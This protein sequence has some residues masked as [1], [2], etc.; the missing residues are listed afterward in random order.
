VSVRFTIG[1]H[2]TLVAGAVRRAARTGAA[3]AVPRMVDLRAVVPAALGRVEFE[4]LEEGREL[5]VVEHALA[6]AM[7]RSGAATSPARTSRRWSGGSTR[8]S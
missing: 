5:E 6:R 8:V 2:E 7:L 3:V 4:L 1:A